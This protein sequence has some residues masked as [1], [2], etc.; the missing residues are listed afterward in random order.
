MLPAP[1]RGA[2]VAASLQLPPA[3]LPLAAPHMDQADGDMAAC[4]IGWP[5]WS[6]GRPSVR[7]TRGFPPGVC[8]PSSPQK[9]HDVEFGTSFVIFAC[10]AKHLAG[11]QLL[12]GGCHSVE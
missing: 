1:Y 12:K 5:G 4:R 6:S 9:R 10:M 11:H 2:E 3:T 8:N 7:A